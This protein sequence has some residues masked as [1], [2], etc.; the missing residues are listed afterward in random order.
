MPPKDS[1]KRGRFKSAP[2]TFDRGI[3]MQTRLQINITAPMALGGICASP[4]GTWVD[5]LAGVWQMKPIT[6]SWLA[7][8]ASATFSV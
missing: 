4:G 5:H 1:H 6:K 2:P 8:A 7:A 3:V